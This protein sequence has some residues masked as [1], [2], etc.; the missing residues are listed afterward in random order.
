V[1]VD[2]EPTFIEHAQGRFSAYAAEIGF[3]I[4]PLSEVEIGLTSTHGHRHRVRFEVA[5]VL[6]L[7]KEL[8]TADAYDLIISHAFLDL[9][10]IAVVVPALLDL[11]H[12]AGYYY[13]TLVFDG[14]TEF[15]PVMG[16]EYDSLIM[17]LYHRS[18]DERVVDG[19][20][21]GHSQ[22]GRRL[23]G[24]LQNHQA[25][26]QAMGASDWVVKAQEAGSAENIFLASILDTVQNEL[27]E[28]P[29]LDKAMFQ[30]WLEARRQQLASGELV[31][32][33]HQLDY[34]GQKA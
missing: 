25:P 3:S 7:P 23:Y 2:L 6:D 32:I 28:H 18:M 33:T 5:D 12:P 24:V 26:I 17:E 31:Y 22:S 27:I 34:F 15:L 9:V 14:L 10:D 30:V 8:A 13:F 29:E 1:A 20:R 4:E 16:E 19:V 11:L 21:A